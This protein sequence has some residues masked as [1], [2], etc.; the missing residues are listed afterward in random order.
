[1][2][3][4]PP[5]PIPLSELVVPAT[6]D[7]VLTL[8]FSIAQGLGL[9]TT[10]WQSVQMIPDLI[11]VNS[12]I[13][14]D[15]SGTVALIAQGGYP[16]LAAQM[17]DESGAPITTWMDLI[18]SDFYN[19][20]R[21]VAQYAS[22]PVPFTNTGGSYPYGPSNPLHFQN[23][24]TGATYT[25]SGNGTVAPG[26]GTVPVVSDAAGTAVT[27]GAGVVLVMTTPLAGVTITALTQSLVGSDAETNPN[28]LIRGQYKLATLCPVATTDQPSPV[29]GA[30]RGAYEYVALTIPQAAVASAVPP[31]A[32]TAQITRCST[33]L[34][35]GSGLVEVFIANESG[36]PPAGDVIAVNAAIQDLAVPDAVTVQAAAATPVLINV[37]ATVY[38]KT[39]SGVTSATIITNIDDA[40]ANYYA[41]L[42]IGGVT[43]TAPNIVPLSE[44]VETI[45]QA[46]VGTLDVVMTLPSTP[47]GLTTS[48]IPQSGTNTITVVFS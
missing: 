28:L 31:Y 29:P 2:S 7:S 34:S 43:T 17:V 4:P 10:A 6:A 45:F 20:T 9:P 22:G 39:S 27:S 47:P 41:S 8:S 26:T 36:S 18:A 35:T 5:V 14:A 21:N 11:N 46:N 33:Q 1:M 44:I 23:V 37:T 38:V 16:S 30:A 48:G 15:Y 19:T 32:V 12:V 13:A 24:V 40:L 3:A 42:P 25:S